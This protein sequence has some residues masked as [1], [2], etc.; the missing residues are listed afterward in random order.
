MSLDQV[1]VVGGGLAGLSAAHSVLEKGGRVVVIDKSSFMGGN[2]TKATSGINGALTQTQ[3]QKGIKDSPEAFYADTAKSARDLGRPELIKALTHNS[4]AAV[5]WLQ[6]AFSLDLSL[7]S[8]LGGHSFERT[9]RGKERFPGMTIT[10]ALMEKLEAIAKASPDRAR[11]ITKAKVNRLTTDGSGAVTG[12]EYANRKGQTFTEKGIVVIATGGYAA[13]FAPDSLL[14]VHRPD[15]LHL[16]TTNGEHC[17]GD[18]IK[19]AQGA[20]AG[21]VDMKQVQ[22]HPTGLVDLKEPDAK[23][24]FLAAEALRGVGGMLLNNEGDRFADE[25][26]HRDYVTGRMWENKRG[27]YR[28]ILNGKASKEI[29]W[30]CKHYCGRGLMKRVASG[31][32]LAAEMGV[33]PAKLQATFDDYNAIASGQKKCPFGKKYFHNLPW[34]LDDFFHVAIVTPVLHYCMGGLHMNEKAEVISS[35]GGSVKNLWAAGEVMGGVHGANRL[36]GNS[37]LDCVV[38]GRIAGQ[39]AG[40]ALRQMKGGVSMSSSVSVGSTSEGSV[41]SSAAGASGGLRVISAAEVAKHNKEEDCWVIVNG[42]VLDVTEFMHDHPGG[43][44]AIMLFAGRDAS[45]E[46]NMLH[47]PEVV[48]KYAPE[49]VIGVIEG[50]AAVSSDAAPASSATGSSGSSAAA[51]GV[52]D[53]AEVAKHNTEKDCW[54]VVHGK[55]YDMTSFLDEHPGGKK[56]VLKVAGQ[57]ATKQ[58]DKFHGPQVLQQYGE[59]LFVANLGEKRGASAPADSSSSSSKSAEGKLNI[60][61]NDDLGLFGELTP[62]G[63]PNWYQGWHNPGYYDDSH[64]AVRRAVREWIETEVTGKIHAWD[65]AKQLPKSLFKSAAA[66]GILQASIGPNWPPVEYAGTKIAGGIKPEEFDAFHWGIIVDEICRAGSGG[67][68]WGLFG[69]LSIGLPPVLYW[70]SKSLKDRV[71]KPCLHGDKFICLCITEPAAGSDVANL[72][73]TATKTPDGK[74]YILNGEKKW[75]TNGVFADFFT[76]ACRTGGPGMGGVSLLLVERS[77][78]GVSTRQMN[79]MGVWASGTTYIT[80]EDVKVPVGNLI[81]KENQ[82]F[83]YI[84]NNFNYERMGFVLQAN[85]FSRVCYEEAY[86]YALKRHTFGKPLMEHQV[87][88]WKLAEMARQIEANWAQTEQLLYQFKTMSKEEAA[89]KLGGPIALAKVQ[90]TKTLEY[91]AREAAQVFGGLSYSRG[92]QG[93]KV[94]RLYREVRAYAIP[95]GSE[96]IMLDLGIKQGMRLAQQVLKGRM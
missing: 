28:L 84:M 22:V 29:E 93:E 38:Y 96:E 19:M 58:F 67:L 89:S 64:K 14:G 5:E 45:E 55:V 24:K 50:G 23:V 54:I 59:Q 40:D 32:E 95:G 73:T 65:E 6:S 3:I 13:D 12:V 80:F 78:A 69:G 20:G 44:K 47:K 42:Q 56:V 36:G 92:G 85:R 90:N 25:L 39:N 53:M 51:D 88:R 60:I 1:I 15:L 16:P 35:G 4:G 31:R 26:G 41:S 68:T 17:T 43:K 66:A 21:V 30:H 87:I 71:V 76:V 37:L 8:R 7:V 91:C 79:C 63:D 72:T 75:I 77:M 52:I 61:D 34:T 49:C 74:H 82:G 27:P 18:G 57:D 9:H 48:E 81:G 11:V 33:S 46:F 2:S 70:G 94:E 10:Y 86:K 83:K 62:Y